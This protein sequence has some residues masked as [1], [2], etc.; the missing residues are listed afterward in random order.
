[1][2]AS[3]VLVPVCG[4]EADEDALALACDMIRPAKGKV[5]VLYVIEVLRS[6]PL[7][8][9]VEAENAKGEDVLQRMETLGKEFHVDLEAEIL[10]ARDAGPAVVQEAVDRGV[11]AI[12]IGEPYRWHHGVFSLGNTAPY[13]LRNAPCPV[14]LWRQGMSTNGKPKKKGDEEGVSKGL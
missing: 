4:M 11:Q 3:R 13:I 14:L 10:R 8:A 1:M 12:V 2:Q 6:L 9:D 7:D 5:Y